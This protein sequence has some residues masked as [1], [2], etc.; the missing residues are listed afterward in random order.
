MGYSQGSNPGSSQALLSTCHHPLLVFTVEQPRHP[1]H[2]GP[3][4]GGFGDWPLFSTGA[5]PSSHLTEAVLEAP[6]LPTPCHVNPVQGDSS[7]GN[8]QGRELALYQSC[9]K[10]L[11][12]DHVLECC[13]LIIVFCSQSSSLH[14]EVNSNLKTLGMKLLILQWFLS[15]ARKTT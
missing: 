15:L 12:L 14:F 9:Q 13:G 3:P 11:T 2:A 6:F 10:F 5:A 1:G 7:F 4:E 8:W